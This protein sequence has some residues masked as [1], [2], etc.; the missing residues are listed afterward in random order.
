M[1]LVTAQVHAND[2]VMPATHLLTLEAP[3]IARA[4]VPGQFV[5][6]RSGPYWDPLLRRPIS[7]A[8]VDGERIRLLVRRVGRGTELIAASR[9]GDD[10]DCL[11]PQGRGFTLDEADRRLM[12]VG[13]GYGVA[14]LAWLAERALE[15]G[16]EVALLVGA[17]TA[18]HVYPARLLPPNV[19][20]HVATVDGSL[21]Q[22]GLV[23]ELM[24]P[25]LD[26]ADAVYACGPH[27]MLA[28][29]ARLAA[30]RRLT[31]RS[32]PVQVALE[33]RMGCAM[34]VCLGCVVR[35]KAGYQRV[36]RDGPVF[37][38]SFVLWEEPYD[39]EFIG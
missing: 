38:A 19:E 8:G 34:G 14:P 7:L 16:H 30:E 5:H 32:L 4:A 29:V 36:C 2:E 18:A 1:Q 22:P 12:L 39:H 13:G 17:S 6:V 24:P 27:A 28:A 21:G 15:R 33:Q 20:Y 10:L 11:G 3:E 31:R 37:P 25:L 35:T 23:T 9:P 26:W